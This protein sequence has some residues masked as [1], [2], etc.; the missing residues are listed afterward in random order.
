MQLLFNLRMDGFCRILAGSAR[1]GHSL[2][3]LRWLEAGTTP[4]IIRYRR[5]DERLV[6]RGCF[7]FAL[8]WVGG[9]IVAFSALC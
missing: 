6:H 1:H 4:S 7:F 5:G 8:V 2:K 9:F 3:L